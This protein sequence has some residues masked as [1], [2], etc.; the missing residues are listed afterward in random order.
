MFERAR[1]L[2]TVD[3]EPLVRDAVRLLSTLVRYLYLRAREG[4]PSPLEGRMTV[5][6]R[7]SNKYPDYWV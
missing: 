2:L 6:V 5:S 4:E 3:I 1:Q 7:Y